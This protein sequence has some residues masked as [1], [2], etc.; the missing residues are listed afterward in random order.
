M[1]RPPGGT[2]G[3]WW[4]P[5]SGLATPS[6]ETYQKLAKLDD[7]L[8]NYIFK[9][10]LRPFFVKIWKNKFFTEKS[11]GHNNEKMEEFWQDLCFKSSIV[12][13]I[14]SLGYSRVVSMNNISGKLL[15]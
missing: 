3:R 1:P 7:F 9:L 8:L 6:N 15:K 11:K 13:Y 4:D 5:F 2:P 10:N 14:T 12:S